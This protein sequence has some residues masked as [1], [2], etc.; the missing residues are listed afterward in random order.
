[1]AIDLTNPT[2]GRLI[3]PR[4][5]RVWVSTARGAAELG[6]DINQA[7]IRDWQRRGRVRS[8]LEAGKRWYLLTDLQIVEAD[9]Y[10]KTRPRAVEIDDEGYSGSQSHH[11]QGQHRRAQRTGG[12]VVQVTSA[13]CTRPVDPDSPF[14]VCQYHQGE[15]FHHYQTIMTARIRAGGAKTICRPDDQPDPQPEPPDYVYYVRFGDRV[16]IGFSSNLPTRIAQLPCDEVLAVE[17][18]GIQLERMRH[19]EFGA[20]RVYANREWFTLTDELQS[21]C[22]MLVKHYGPPTA[23]LGAAA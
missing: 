17:P 1:M 12:C 4:S 14:D 20:A 23:H 5:G 15:I 10:R 21:H 16:K 8:R 22:D 9:T 19:A 2:D 13:L 3:D 11:T 18:G 6:P 7:T